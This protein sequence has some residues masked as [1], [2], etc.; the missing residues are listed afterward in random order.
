MAGDDRCNGPVDDEE[1]ERGQPAIA[2]LFFP[3]FRSFAQSVVTD[4]RHRRLFKAAGMAARPTS[5]VA[6][7][8]IRILS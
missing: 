1:A 6:P 2:D 8:W 4:Q 7:V 5:C 3:S